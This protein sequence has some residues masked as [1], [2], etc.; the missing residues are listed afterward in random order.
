ME[1]TIPVAELSGKFL[2]I[3]AATILVSRNVLIQSVK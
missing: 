1:V 2:T 3:E